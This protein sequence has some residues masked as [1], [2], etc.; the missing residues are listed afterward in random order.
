MSGLFHNVCAPTEHS[1]DCEGWS[2]HVTTYPA[3]IHHNSGIELDVGMQLASRLQLQKSCLDA[4]LYVSGE[5]EKW[6]ADLLSDT[7]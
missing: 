5:G 3:G 2:E 1:A 4:L 6:S 7:T